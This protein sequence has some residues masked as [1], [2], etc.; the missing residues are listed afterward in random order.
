MS[1]TPKRAGLGRIALYAVHWFIIVN[2]LVEIVYASW[3][4]FVVLAPE[5]ASGPL[6]GAAATLPFELVA[7]RRMYAQETWLAI[8]GL[9]VYLA[10]TE[11]GPRLRR[12]RGF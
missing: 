6:F 9:A 12:Y 7:K 10:L 11:I 2:F 5:G 4:V 3:I 1:D 8:A